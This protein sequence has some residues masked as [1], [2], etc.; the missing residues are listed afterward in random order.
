MK[1]IDILVGPMGAGTSFLGYLQHIITTNLGDTKADNCWDDYVLQFKK[2]E[3]LTPTA[4]QIKRTINNINNATESNYEK[5]ANAIE[6][7]SELLFHYYPFGLDKFLNLNNRFFL[8]CTKD[9]FFWCY[10]LGLIKNNDLPVDCRGEHNDDL[11]YE[12]CNKEWQNHVETKIKCTFDYHVDYEEVFV[13]PNKGV[14]QMLLKATPNGRSFNID[15]IIDL[16]IKYNSRN[17]E[18]LEY[19]TN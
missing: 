17:N 5:F 9:R 3:P 14:I 4:K 13:E 18:I 2:F 19:V 1:S 15:E 7:G 11:W 16:L 12:E 6:E 10:K 8:S